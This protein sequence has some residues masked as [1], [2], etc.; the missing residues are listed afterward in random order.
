MKQW[1]KAKCEGKPEDPNPPP[2]EPEAEPSDLDEAE[3][4]SIE[5]WK[6]SFGFLTLIVI[7]FLFWIRYWVRKRLDEMA[8]AILANKRRLDRQEGVEDQFDD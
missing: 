5:D 2:E 3:A 1:S 4:G 8:G 7:G 6:L